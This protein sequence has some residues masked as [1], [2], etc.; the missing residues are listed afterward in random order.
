[1]WGLARGLRHRDPVRH[2]SLTFDPNVKISG[3]LRRFSRTIFPSVF[4]DLRSPDRS[5]NVRDTGPKGL[6]VTSVG[7]EATEV[8]V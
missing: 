7:V 1:M 5:Q 3:I 8:E 2:V 6:E 4:A